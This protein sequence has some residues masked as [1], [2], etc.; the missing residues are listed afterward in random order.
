[1]TLSE[2]Q[3]LCSNI[4]YTQYKVIFL[5]VVVKFIQNHQLYNHT[6]S[7]VQCERLR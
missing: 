3:I 2:S 7:N 5:Y 4:V 6:L 1:M